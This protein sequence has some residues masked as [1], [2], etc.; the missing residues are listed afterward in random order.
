MSLRDRY[1]RAL[2]A[3]GHRQ[4]LMA[5][6]GKY[7]VYEHPDSPGRKFYLGPSGALRVGAT[8]AG[9]IPCSQKFKDKLLEEAL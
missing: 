3:R 1:A 4:D 9:S 2:V 5:R 8:V 6:T 7:D